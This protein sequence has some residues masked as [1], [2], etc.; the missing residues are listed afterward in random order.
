MM[1]LLPGSRWA[2]MMV[3]RPLP[4]PWFDGCGDTDVDFWSSISF[5]SASSS[6]SSLQWSVKICFPKSRGF[7]K[8]VSQMEQGNFPS[9]SDI[10]D[11]T[12]KVVKRKLGQVRLR[13]FKPSKALSVFLEGANTGCWKY[14]FFCL[15]S[16]KKKKTFRWQNNLIS[17]VQI[18]FTVLF[19]RYFL[20]FRLFLSAEWSSVSSSLS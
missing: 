8:D 13:R 1:M 17:D 10:F 15:D 18:H 3:P 14:S 11:W 7:E 20:N 5:A 4:K 19:F 2:S 16:L 6:S 12:K 9:P